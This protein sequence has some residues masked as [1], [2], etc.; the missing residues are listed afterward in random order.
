M[1]FVVEQKGERMSDLIRRQDAID[2]VSD[3]GICI[4]KIV[5]LP[6]AE[7]EQK[8]G[9]WIHCKYP[10]GECSVCHKIINIQAN[11]AV[12]CPCCGSRNTGYEE[13]E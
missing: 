6:S 13:Y 3:C 8:T 11:E 5:D 4:Q 2:A 7:Q 12:Y 10:L 1:T 9:K